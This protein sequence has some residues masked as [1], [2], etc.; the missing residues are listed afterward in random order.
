MG[1]YKYSTFTARLL[2]EYGCP[3]RSQ[4]GTRQSDTVTLTLPIQFSALGARRSAS[5]GS[6][7]SAAT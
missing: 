1:V 6:A 5:D 3:V 2:R 7:L 4:L